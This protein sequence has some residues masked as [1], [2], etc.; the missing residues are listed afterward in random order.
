MVT[1]IIQR[2]MG[3]TGTYSTLCWL[4]L[5]EQTLHEIKKKHALHVKNMYFCYIWSSTFGTLLKSVV[6]REEKKTTGIKS[7]NSTSNSHHL[8]H[9]Y[10]MNFNES[11]TCDVLLI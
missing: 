10:D 3:L 8:T 9:F 5:V 11:F 1:P 4:S 6:L 7:F 2:R